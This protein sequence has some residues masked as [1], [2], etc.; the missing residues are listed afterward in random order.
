MYIQP[1]LDT[2]RWVSLTLQ[3]QQSMKRS[4]YAVVS[5]RAIT[6]KPENCGVTL[7]LESL[8]ITSVH[9]S[10]LSSQGAVYSSAVIEHAHGLV[11]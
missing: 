9:M 10:A 3:Q 5:E 8:C 1:V 7:G 6:D 2:F 11:D 4:G